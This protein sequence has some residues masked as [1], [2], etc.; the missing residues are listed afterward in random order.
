LQILGFILAQ[1]VFIFSRKLASLT[2][3]REATLFFK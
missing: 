2:K 3:G 1:H